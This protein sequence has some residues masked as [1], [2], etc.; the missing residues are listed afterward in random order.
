MNLEIFLL[1]YTISITYNQVLLL[2]HLLTLCDGPFPSGI[3]QNEWA[4]SKN[5]SSVTQTLYISLEVHLSES[6][7]WKYKWFPNKTPVAY[8]IILL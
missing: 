2:T 1:S 8:Q 5:M 6:K 3:D 7:A 4:D